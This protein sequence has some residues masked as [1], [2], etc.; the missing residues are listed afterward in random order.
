MT[1]QFKDPIYEYVNID[2]DVV[3]KIIDTPT[4]QR[5]KDIRQTSYA[6]LYPAAYHNRFVHSLGVYYLGKIAFSA[7]KSQLQEYGKGTGVEANLDRIQ[8]LFELACLLH[9]VGHAPFS[10]TGEAFYIDETGT[11]YQSLKDCVDEDSF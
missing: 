3:N 11:L 8:Q 1:K 2:G 7:I 6:P 5:L 10:H 4:F 9:D